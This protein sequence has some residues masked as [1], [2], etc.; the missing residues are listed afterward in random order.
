MA[1]TLT[2][3]GA[4]RKRIR[5]RQPVKRSINLAAV[6]QKRFNWAVAVPSVILIIVISALFSKFFVVDRFLA[7]AAAQGEV[8]RL[9]SEL[10]AGYAEIASFGELTEQYAHYTFSGMTQE[11]L[12]RADRVEAIRTIRTV[13]LRRG[14][15]N[16][17][18]ISGNRLTISFTAGTLGEVN[19]MAAALEREEIVSYATVSNATTNVPRYEEEEE[20]VT[21]TVVADL[22]LIGGD[23]P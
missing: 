14:E 4:A 23:E 20:T 7:V 12:T 15:V 2:R 8:S 5:G 18:S 19:E 11:E 3:P 6:D 9:Q 1:L 21:A 16:S 10:D 13:A 22:Q 17:W